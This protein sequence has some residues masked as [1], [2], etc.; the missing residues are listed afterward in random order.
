MRNWF[1][2]S[3]LQSQLDRIEGVLRRLERLAVNHFTTI[4]RHQDMADHTLEDV[5]A[6]SE[7]E[8]TEIDSLISLITGMKTLLDQALAGEPISPAGKARVNKIFDAIQAQRDEVTAAI[9]ANTPSNPT[10]EPTPEPPAPV[11]T[12][13]D[14]GKVASDQSQA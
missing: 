7:A 2:P 14:S 9:L 6:N 11:V 5:L 12:D 4:E 3:P 10:P 13:G 8:K 1:G